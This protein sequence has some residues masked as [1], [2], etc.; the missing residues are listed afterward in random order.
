MAPKV[1]MG[2][3]VT[4]FPLLVMTGCLAP[5]QSTMSTESI[6]VP[7]TVSR[8]QALV[9]LASHIPQRLGASAHADCPPAT[10]FAFD[11]PKSNHEPDVFELRPKFMNPLMKETD[12]CTDTRERRPPVVLSSGIEGITGILPKDREAALLQA[13]DVGDPAA[14]GEVVLANVFHL[15]RFW[16]ARIPVHL[17]GHDSIIFQLEHFPIVSMPEPDAATNRAIKG[18][19]SNKVNDVKEWLNQNVAGHTQIRLDFP[20]DSITLTE[21]VALQESTPQTLTIDDIVLSSEAQGTPK[22]AYDPVSAINPLFFSINRITSLEE[23]YT[24]MVVR[25]GHWVEQWRVQGPKAPKPMDLMRQY[26]R[27]AANNW[28]SLAA[29][30]AE[31][32]DHAVY[33]T[34][35]V[36][37]VAKNRTRN[38]TSEVITA[39][40][41]AQSLNWLEKVQGKIQDLTLQRAYPMFLQAALSKSGYIRGDARLPDMD[42]RDPKNGTFLVKDPSL[43]KLRERLLDDGFCRRFLHPSAGQACGD[44]AKTAK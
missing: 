2:W 33:R 24:D 42:R 18:F 34:V 22:Q 30:D 13:L 6:V 36:R 15:K 5:R 25:Q 28:K 26:L 14:S 17:L 39:L 12:R 8:Q 21:Q 37:R 29:A 16:F 1:T 11:M 40:E 32:Q 9:E 43:S 4:M 23:K 27:M 3:P 38:C 7:G 31:S 20:D 35:D 44:W 41:G 19:L 10:T